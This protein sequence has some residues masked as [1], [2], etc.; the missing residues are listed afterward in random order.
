ME[1]SLLRLTDKV[2]IVIGGGGL[3]NQGIGVSSCRMFAA[4]GAKVIA[5][6]RD[7]DRARATAAMITDQ[8]GDAM[9]I[10][11]DA[12]DPQQIDN[13][14]QRVL[15]SYGRIDCLVT[16]FAS[17]KVAPAQDLAEDDWNRDMELNLKYVWLCARAVAATMMERKIE[18]SI[19]AISSIRAH[20]GSFHQVSYGVAKA[21]LESLIRT[22]A[23]EWGEHGIRVNGVAPGA[24]GTPQLLEQ[25]DKNPALEQ[26]MRAL[27]PM[28]RI[29]T[30]D[31]IA[32]VVLFLSSA[33][34][35]YV[36]GQTI[37]AD[38]GYLLNHALLMYRGNEWVK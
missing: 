25:L 24:T 7:E 35:G 28:A 36:S 3:N 20:T 21:G 18:G 22:L 27:V 33:L 9:A 1:S 13:M 12:T 37:I 34:A 4:A 8:G 26:K 31:E 29:G 11:A 15:D 17:G 5:V 16:V 38:G 2:V 30:P 23:V 6:D 19:V 14:V 32:G 10:G